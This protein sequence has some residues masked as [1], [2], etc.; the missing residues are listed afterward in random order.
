MKPE[1][2]EKLRVLAEEIRKWTESNV[3]EETD[4]DELAKQAN[5]YKKRMREILQEIE[6][7]N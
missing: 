1:T 6:D 2:A 3:D 5:T 7:E 4:L